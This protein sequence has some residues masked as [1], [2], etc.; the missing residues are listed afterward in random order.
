[1]AFAPARVHAYA[2]CRSSH[3]HVW[4]GLPK[5]L[6]SHVL[7]HPKSLLA[8]LPNTLLHHGLCR[9][10]RDSTVVG[11]GSALS[12]SSAAASGAPGRSWGTSSSGTLAARAAL[13]CVSCAMMVSARLR[14]SLSSSSLR[15]RERTLSLS[16]P[17]SSSLSVSDRLC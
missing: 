10:S 1:M 7:Q 12:A 6:P 15:S 8:H 9:G 17:T 16:S 3:H 2:E 13:A 11:R 4:G 5:D 14:E